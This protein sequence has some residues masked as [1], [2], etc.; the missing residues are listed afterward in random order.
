MKFTIAS[1]A[2]GKVAGVVGPAATK[3]V[4]KAK[5]HAPEIMIGA[6]IVLGVACVV[7]A[8]VDTHE[9]AGDIIEEHKKEIESVKKID[10]IVEKE[11]RKEI[12]RV[13]MRTAGKLVVVYLPSMA[14]GIASTAMFLSAHHIMLKR[15][16][17][18]TAAYTALSEAFKGYRERVVDKYGEEEDF[19]LLHGTR[20][21]TDEEKAKAIE[22][23]VDTKDLESAMAIEDGLSLYARF[24]D[25]S[26]RA[27]EDDAFTNRNFLQIQEDYFTRR[28]DAGYPVFLNE[29]YDALGME[30]SPAGAV[31]GWLP[32][33]M[34][35]KDGY[36]SFGIGKGDMASRRFVNQLEASFLCDF[37]V[38]GVI[39]D[40]I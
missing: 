18:L 8:C 10:G 39:W 25:S 40:K 33:K 6:G 27:W 36:V 37:N 21:L 28:L 22:D 34:G 16:G 26:C 32:K 38:D 3:I 30:R 31:V 1:K 4:L 11:F 17:E 14:L 7:K 29:V 19:A 35:G 15:L 2:A 12:S 20:A 5:K 9:K 23:G 13:Y 24:F